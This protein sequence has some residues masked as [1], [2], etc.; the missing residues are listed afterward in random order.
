MNEPTEQNA[1][2]IPNLFLI[3]RSSVKKYA[4]EV[5]KRRRAGKFTRVSQDFLNSVEA[6]LDSAIRTIVSPPEDIITPTPGTK[7]TT[8]LAARKAA[9]KLDLLAMKIVSSKV[10]RHPSLGCTLK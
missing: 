10:M 1:P 8:G 5:S 9:I 2:S 3:N 6:E 4:L 7:F